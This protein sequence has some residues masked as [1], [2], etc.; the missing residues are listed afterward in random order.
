MNCV[1]CNNVFVMFFILNFVPVGQLGEEGF[2]GQGD[3][4]LR[5]HVF[6]P[7]SLQQLHGCHVLTI[8]FLCD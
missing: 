6:A 8:I 5:G 4:S 2:P 3:D 1:H 7:V